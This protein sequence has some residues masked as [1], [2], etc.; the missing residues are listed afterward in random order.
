M[1]KSYPY[2]INEINNRNLNIEYKT[3]IEKKYFVW[4]TKIERS[5][6]SFAS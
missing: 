1:L 6:C 4:N 2:L 5:P 3:E